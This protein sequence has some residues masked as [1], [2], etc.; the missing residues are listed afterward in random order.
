MSTPFS[1]DDAV[2]R[3]LVAELGGADALEVLQVFLADSADKIARLGANNQGRP[4][5]KREAHSIKSSAATFGFIELST[6]AK[7]LE[8][9][10]ETMTPAK[11]QESIFEL[12]QV[13]ETTRQF[14]QVNLLN[15]GLGMAT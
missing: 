14:A 3:S 9:G 10:A 6:L 13:F 11:L 5:I 7:E 8:F 4:Q 15:A 12:R 2:F 1:F